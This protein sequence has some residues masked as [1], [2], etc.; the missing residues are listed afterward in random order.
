M[1]NENNCYTP[2]PEMG[3]AMRVYSEHG[4]SPTIAN[5]NILVTQEVDVILG[6]IAFNIFGGN[7]RADRP[8]GGFYVHEAEVTKTLDAANGLNPTCSQ[9]GVAIVVDT[10]EEN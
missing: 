7:K 4:P 6:Q 2:W 10:S 1:R 9:G 8:N 5:H 3:Q